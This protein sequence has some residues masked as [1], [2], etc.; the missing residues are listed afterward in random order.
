MIKFIKT[1][2]LGGLVFLVPVVVI[3]IVV[4]KAASVMMAVAEPMAALVPF[5]SIGGIALANILAAVIVLLICFVAGLV[6]RT[7]RAKALANAAETAVLQKL[8]GYAFL[9]GITSTLSP[10]ETA[11]LKPVLVAR[12]STAR[13][14][15]EVERIGDDRVAVYFPGSPNAWSGVVE[16]VPTDQLEYIDKP[17]MSIIE[18]AEQ[19][20]RGSH[21][22][23]AG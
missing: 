22:M 17:M 2:I 3:I 14:G 12:G 1:T 4:L 5:D 18:H 15:L 23:L 16:I 19:L 11:G 20:G 6:A 13:V 9:K 10:D 7:R 8:P 21:D